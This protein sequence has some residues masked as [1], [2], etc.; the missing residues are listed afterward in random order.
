[1]KSTRVHI[2]SQNVDLSPSQVLDVFELLIQTYPRYADSASRKAVQVVVMKLM[3]R[4]ETGE[5]EL[6]VAE[7][8]LDRLSNEVSRIAKHP[9]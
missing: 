7:Q 8:I 2:N 3:Q 6:G 9:K 1:M 5:H 4:Y